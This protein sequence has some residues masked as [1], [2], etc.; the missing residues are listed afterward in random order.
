MQIQQNVSLKHYN[1]F[2]VEASARFFAPFAS[3]QDLEEIVSDKYF[4]QNKSMIL[5]GG[6]NILFTKN[7]DG[8]VIKN[9]LKGIKLVKEDDEYYYVKAYGGE[10][11]HEFVLYCLSHNYAGVENLSLIPGTVGASPVQNIG[12]YGIEIKD[13]LY[14][15]EAFHLYE[16][17]I[18]RFLLS[19]CAFGY[20][21][22]I[23]KNNLKD[24][25]VILNVTY[26]LR[27]QPVFNV[28]YGA[29]EQEL[30]KMGVKE[31]SIRAISQA[32][33][34]IRTSKLPDPKQI[35][36]AG[37][38]FKNPVVEKEKYELL[39]TNFPAVVGYETPDK[40]MVKL[41]AGWL[42]EQCG[43]K[44]FRKGDAG[45]NAMQA[46]VLVNYGNAKG[47]EIFDLSN[48]IIMSVEKK[49]GVKLSVELKIL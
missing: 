40:A 38:F 33:I 5:G 24:K 2:G 8:L 10:L 49:F 9:N 15:L 11:W 17:S 4:L 42:I 19:A 6:S 41:A 47:S 21:D 25:F 23:F 31:L 22:S 16:K 32:V 13:V 14:E 44:G 46:L 29:I 7:F 12:A 3:L 36:N 43:W 1:S 35:G 28:S 39:K 34:N 18:W 30:E 37:S 45:V 26:R 48:E 20:R 27:K